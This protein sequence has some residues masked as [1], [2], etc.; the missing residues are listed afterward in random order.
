MEYIQ[1]GQDN[2]TPKNSTSVYTQL[3]IKFFLRSDTSQSQTKNGIKYWKYYKEI[4]TYQIGK[5]WYKSLVFLT[6]EF[7]KKKKECCNT[8]QMFNA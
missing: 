4:F 6:R 5:V 3:H 8:F 1:Q 7:K 2:S